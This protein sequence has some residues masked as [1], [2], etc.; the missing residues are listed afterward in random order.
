MAVTSRLYGASTILHKHLSLVWQPFLYGLLICWSKPINKNVMEIDF[1]ALF[2]LPILEV[3][4]ICLNVSFWMDSIKKKSCSKQ[5]VSGLLTFLP[6]WLTN[7]KKSPRLLLSLIGGTI[8]PL[9]LPSKMNP[10]TN[11]ALYDVSYQIQKPFVI[12]Q[13]PF[14]IFFFFWWVSICFPLSL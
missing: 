3:L 5:A 4:F 11:T 1:Y 6:P 13:K 2:M 14:V 12:I 7:L 10:L 9:D 8:S